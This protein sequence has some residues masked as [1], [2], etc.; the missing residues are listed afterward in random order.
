MNSNVCALP[1]AFSPEPSIPDQGQ[2]CVNL[3][4]LLATTNKYNVSF[5][6]KAYQNAKMCC[7]WNATINNKYLLP[8]WPKPGNTRL[9]PVL[10]DTVSMYPTRGPYLENDINSYTDVLTNVTSQ[11]GD[12]I[13]DPA[14]LMKLRKSEPTVHSTEDGTVLPPVVKNI[15]RTTQPIVKSETPSNGPPT[16][17]EAL[18]AR[19]L[20]DHKN[21]AVRK[22]AKAPLRQQESKP[23][24]RVQEVK[25]SKE[26]RSDQPFLKNV[27]EAVKGAIF[28]MTHPD[29][30][31]E[32]D[33]IQYVCTR[34]DRICYFLFLLLVII[35]S[36]LIVLLVIK[37]FV[38]IIG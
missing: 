21:K 27:K 14:T 11:D 20:T 2:G 7:D 10:D 28:D 9:L 19:I 34:K 8:K 4:N 22:Q 38:Y 16:E 15:L 35:L 33:K 31:P 23:S 5:S 13:P 30:L 12:W 36:V 1:F 29:T 17:Q 3:P 6:N 26:N 37:F 24:L 18:Q 32:K 25:E